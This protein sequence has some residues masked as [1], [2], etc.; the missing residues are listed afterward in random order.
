M[1]KGDGGF[2]FHDLRHCAATNLRRAGVDTTT[3]MQI[4]WHTSP[5]MWKR[6]NHIQEGDLT[7]AA[8]RQGQYLDMNTPE[9][10]DGT[11][12]RG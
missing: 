11:A 8:N 1:R 2:R 3:A 7:Q 4:V 9:T 10:L 6:Y 12:E 5:R